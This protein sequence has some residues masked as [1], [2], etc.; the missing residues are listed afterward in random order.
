MLILKLLQTK[1]KVVDKIMINH[2]LRLIRP[3]KTVVMVIKLFVVMMTNIQNQHRCIKIKML[4]TNSW[5]K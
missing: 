1:Y 4:Y 3:M 2:T 5:K